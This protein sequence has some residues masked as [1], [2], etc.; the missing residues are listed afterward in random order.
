VASPIK[1]SKAHVV[2]NFYVSTRKYQ[3]LDDLY[4][5][6]RTGKH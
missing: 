5:L 6:E 4:P 2:L 3:V 1:S